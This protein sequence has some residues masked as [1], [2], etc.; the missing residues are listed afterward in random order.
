MPTH[1]IENSK[2]SHAARVTKNK[3][4]SSQTYNRM[5]ARMFAISITRGEEDMATQRRLWLTIP[6]SGESPSILEH[7]SELV[8]HSYRRSKPKV[9]RL[10][11]SA[12]KGTLPISYSKGSMSLP[13][14]EEIFEAH[15]LRSAVQMS[16]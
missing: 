7:P 2:V 12:G 4:G 6:P 1:F 8:G 13:A 10:T 5:L 3:S 14:D 16:H 11:S 15:D 9:T